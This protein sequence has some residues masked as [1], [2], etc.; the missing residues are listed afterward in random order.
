MIRA[1]KERLKVAGIG[2][3]TIPAQIAKSDGR[4]FCFGA[5]ATTD[6]W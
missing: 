1:A 3:P 6:C 4:Y 5:T 2:R